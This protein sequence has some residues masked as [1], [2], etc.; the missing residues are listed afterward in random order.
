[1]KLILKHLK[2]YKLLVFFNASI[3]FRV[4]TGGIGHP[5]GYGKTFIDVPVLRTGMSATY[6]LWGLSV[7]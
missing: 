6:R 2:H 1:M 4:C 3:R 5:N 7:S